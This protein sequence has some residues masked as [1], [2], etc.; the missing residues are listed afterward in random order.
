LR[1]LGKYF[2]RKMPLCQNF[3][4]LLTSARTLGG[5]DDPETLDSEGL[6]ATLEDADDADDDL[7][8]DSSFCQWRSLKRARTS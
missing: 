5:V 3:V 1:K 4:C 7:P 6:E 2:V 8:V